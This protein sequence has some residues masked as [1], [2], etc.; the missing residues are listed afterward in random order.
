[1]L[2]QPVYYYHHDSI[3]N[4]AASLAHGNCGKPRDLNSACANNIIL[5]KSESPNVDVVFVTPN[6]KPQTSNKVLLI[7]QLL[8]KAELLPSILMMVVC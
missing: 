4:C 7:N 8:S 2:Q 6:F 1:M 5:V 3:S